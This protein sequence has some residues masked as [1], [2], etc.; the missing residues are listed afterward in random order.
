MKPR[1][2]AVLNA[3]ASPPSPLHPLVVVAI[4]RLVL[5]ASPIHR[6]LALRR[7]RVQVPCRRHSDRP[8]LSPQAIID[9]DTPDVSPVE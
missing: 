1:D 9:N 5:F 2:I 7:H 3:R 8:P 6:H 4:R